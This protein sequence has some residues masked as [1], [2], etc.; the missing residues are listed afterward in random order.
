MNTRS[1]LVGVLSVLFAL[2]PALAATA[3]QA[4]CQTYLATSPSPSNIPAVT[5]PGVTQTRYLCR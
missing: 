5:G 4:T 1:V 3:T 2:H